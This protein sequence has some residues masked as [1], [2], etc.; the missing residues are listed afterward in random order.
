M[1]A[2]EQLHNAAGWLRACRRPLLLTHRRPDGDALGALSALTHAL[3]RRGLDPQPTLY[4]PLPPRYAGVPGLVAPRRWDRESAALAAACDAVVIVDT[5]A[6]SQLEPAA[7]FLRQAPRTLV[8]DHHPTRDDVGIRPGDLRLID[9][10]AGAVCLVVAELLPA[11]H[12]ALDTTLASALFLGIATDLG[13]F[14]FPG[15]DARALRIAADLVAAGA[16]S[17]TL[18]GAIY[19]REPAAK[20]RL[21]GR[22]LTS[23]DVRADGRL[24]VLA[25]RRADFAAAG[26]D[27]SMTE[28]LVNEATRL[29][30]TE[31]TVLLTEEADGAVRVN[32]RSKSWLDAAQLARTLGGG[33]HTRAA[34]ARLPGPWE[35]A[36]PRVLAALEAALAAGPPAAAPADPPEQSGPRPGA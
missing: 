16:R 4:E 35:Q 18:Y 32:L 20:L 3:R 21:I 11:L 5:C 12:V 36:V 23:L 6:W 7:A 26:A 15:T 14:R 9:D 24:A 2:P 13:W 1:I 33:G 28:D 17:H 31:A 8:I 22:M 10:S 29:E 34:G 19:E 30:G 25:L 27:G